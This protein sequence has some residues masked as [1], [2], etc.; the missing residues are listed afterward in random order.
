MWIVRIVKAGYTPVCNKE[1]MLDSEREFR[2]KPSTFSRC[3]TTG[4]LIRV[5]CYR[6]LPTFVCDSCEYAKTIHRQIFN[7]RAAQQ[8]QAF[9]EE[10]H[11]SRITDVQSIHLSLGGHRY[12]VTLLMAILAILSPKI[13]TKDEVQAYETFSAWVQT[14]HGTRIKRLGSGGEF[15]R[16]GTPHYGRYAST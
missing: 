4:A 9:G 10:A 3:F 1:L 7:E 13:R 12:Y 5:S 15:T 14:Q 8:A 2:Q 16:H 6:Q 11:T